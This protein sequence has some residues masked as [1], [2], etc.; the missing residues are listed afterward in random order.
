MAS[1]DNRPL[2]PHLQIYRWP[3]SM[4]TSILNRVTGVGL[5]VGTLVLIYWLIAAAAGPESFATAQALLGSWVGRLL[6][7]G[8]T[9]ALFFH[10]CNG[11]RH[12]AWDAGWGFEIPTIDATGWIVVLASIVLTVTAWV[13]GYAAMGVL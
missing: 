1:T 6:L 9:W 8:W 13:L 7:F 10:L 2:S 3:L 11:I 5:T 4:L 12:M